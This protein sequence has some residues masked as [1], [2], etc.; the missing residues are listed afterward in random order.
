MRRRTPN[1]GA[2]RSPGIATVYCGSRA[3]WLLPFAAGTGATESLSSRAVR[4]ARRPCGSASL[5]PARPPSARDRTA[6]VAAKSSA[7]PVCCAA[8]RTSLRCTAGASAARRLTSIAAPAP[9]PSPASRPPPRAGRPGKINW[10]ASRAS[11]AF[12]HASSSCASSAICARCSRSFGFQPS[13]SG[14]SSW[15]MRLR[16]NVRWRLVES[17]RQGWPR[18]FRY[19]SMS[20]RLAWSSGR[21]IA[22]PAVSTFGL[23]PARPSVHAPRRNLARTVSA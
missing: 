7:A 2:S 19:A 15:R 18:A 6:S 20:L 3:A 9:E 4:S 10:A 16:V 12:H 11:S 1:S 17:S 22:A 14:S 21:K 5:C 8:W 23:I 13:S